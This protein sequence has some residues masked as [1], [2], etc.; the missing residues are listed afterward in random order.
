[1]ANTES[2][3]NTPETGFFDDVCT[4]FDRA[5]PFVKAADGKSA[6]AKGIL[7]M[8]KACNSVYK[9]EFPIK[10]N[11]GVEL[12]KGYRVQHSHHKLPTK[13]GIRYSKKVN[14]DE[15]KALAAL[16][17]Y[18]CAIVNVPFGGA[19]GGVKINP[20]EYTVAELE[21]ITRRYTSELIKKNF[22]GPG[23]DVPAPDYGTG[24]REMAWIV[25]TYQA[26]NQGQIDASG[27]VTGKPLALHG[28]AG[29]SEATGRGV[30]FATREVCNEP[31]EMTKVG[32]QTGLTNKKV[33]V[34]GLGNVGYWAAKLIQE[35]GGMI[36]GICEQE[37]A[38]YNENGLNVDDVKKYRD[39]RLEENKGKALAAQVNA[40]EGFKESKFF[41][42][43]AEGLE[44]QCDILVP[45][46]LENQLTT[47]NIGKIKAKII[48]EGANGPTTPDAAEMFLGKE[49]DNNKLIIPDMYANAGGV[50]VSYFEWLKNLSHVAMGRINKRFEENQ[51]RKIMDV[52]AKTTGS[53]VSEEARKLIVHGASEH[54]LV[55]SGLEET[56]K[57]AYQEILEIRNANDG[58][59]SMRAA[60]F[61]CAIEKIVKSYTALGIFP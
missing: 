5:A 44:Q 9:F 6:P 45:A 27:C 1:M 23:I 46:A 50:T 14:E 24:E 57:N 16:M 54:D 51:A 37:G 42:N 59:H 8:I 32:L 60:A 39:Q 7:D 4:H 29:R 58:L 11:G 19:K 30:Y 41:K 22:I 2:Q 20:K 15:V 10:R 61:V 35:G 31:T 17:T 56:M 36:V 43:T 28:I 53:S 40:I 3:N 49:G 25:D 38:I 26:F 34:Q 55:N 52:I 21:S 33:I 47:A 13:G 48:V 12:I 18:K